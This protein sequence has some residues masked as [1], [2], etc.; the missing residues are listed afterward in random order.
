MHQWWGRRCRAC[1]APTPHS[2]RGEA[3]L[4]LAARVPRGQG[5][6]HA[7]SALRNDVEA[8][9][10]E[11]RIEAEGGL[12]AVLPHGLKADTVNQ[13]QLPARGGEQRFDTRLVPLLGDP[14]HRKQGHNIPIEQPQSSRS[15]SFLHQSAGLQQNVVVGQKP[16]VAREQDRRRQSFLASLG[17]V[18][19]VMN[20]DIAAARREFTERPEGAVN[21]LLPAGPM[22]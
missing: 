20:A 10:A 18:T 11:V 2:C 6:N 4:A 12:G 3:C 7:V 8:F 15:Q 5:R 16:G 13:A 17:Q 21:L 14:I 22:L 9:F 19:V 1:P